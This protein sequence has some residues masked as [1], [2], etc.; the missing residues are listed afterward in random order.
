MS[1]KQVRI[2]PNYIPLTQQKYC[3]LPCC[4]QWVMLR[5]GLNLISQDEMAKD[6]GVVI[7][8]EDQRLFNIKMKVAKKLPQGKLG[9]GTW[10]YKIPQFLKKHKIPLT[11]TRVYPSKIDNIQNFL[12]ENLKCGNDIIVSFNVAAYAKPGSGVNYGHSCVIDSV[13]VKNKNVIV[14]LGDPAY[15][16]RKFFD[17]DLQKLLDGMS[18]KYGEEKSFK[19]FHGKCPK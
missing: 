10:V 4:I 9:Y 5:R 8:P 12:C 13:M 1:N 16:H 2:K 7:A 14:T 15:S 18:T 17:I 11:V 3:C 6:L 19:V